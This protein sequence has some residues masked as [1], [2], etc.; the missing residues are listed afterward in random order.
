MERTILLMQQAGITCEEAAMPH[1]Y[2]VTDGEE[3]FAEGLK[4]GNYLR[5]KLD[6][7]RLILHCGGGSLK[8]QF[9]KADK[10]GAQFAIIIGEH[11]RK[12][13][14]VSIKAL[15]EELPQQTL[16]Q[17]ELAEYLRLKISKK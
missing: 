6:D 5:G 15:R 10:S 8:N 16:F 12:N 14:S 11:E 13:H 7:L 9:K 3:S 17:V 4:L 2:L 1:A